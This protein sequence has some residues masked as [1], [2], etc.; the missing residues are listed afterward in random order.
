MKSIQFGL[1]IAILPLT[2]IDAEAEQSAKARY[3]QEIGASERVNFSGKLRM[4]S[5]RVVATS[6]NFAADVDVEKSGADMLAAQAEFVKIAEALENGNAELGIFGEE[7]RQK[8]RLHINNLNEKWLTVAHDID[9]LASDPTETENLTALGQNSG[10][11]LDAAKVLVSEL[12]AQYSDP[13]AMLQADAMLVDISGRQRMLAQRMS[14]N[15][16]LVASD[17]TTDAAKDELTATMQLFETS[18]RALRS[19]MP[20]AGIKSPPNDAISKGLNTVFDNWQALKP[21]VETV[22]ASGALEP[23]QRAVVYNGMN[24]M[25]ANMN[26]VV[27]LYAQSSKLGGM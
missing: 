24:E 21:M 2:T 14:K 3:A 17:I 4:L 6:C 9:A 23:A 5:Q 25:T 27:G 26:K 10:P 11:L 12:S 15:V 19:G 18:L 22:L 13:A 1:A 8:T 16:C 20:E 7:K